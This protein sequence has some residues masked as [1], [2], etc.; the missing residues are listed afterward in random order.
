M[1]VA[2]DIPALRQT[3]QHLL[4]QLAAPLGVVLHPRAIVNATAHLGLALLCPPAP[5]LITMPFAVPTANS[6]STAAKPVTP[7]WNSHPVRLI[8]EKV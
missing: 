8:P 6:V 2:I 4:E 7:S 1:V 3:W 5:L